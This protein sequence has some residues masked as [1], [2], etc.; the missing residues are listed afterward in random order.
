MG[1]TSPVYSLGL[2]NDDSYNGGGNFSG[3]PGDGFILR[4][5]ANTL[6]T[7]WLTY[8]GGQG[9]DALWGVD[10]YSDQRLAIVGYCTGA[11]LDYPLYDP[12]D[13]WFQAAPASA[14][15]V[16]ELL[17]P[18]SPIGVAETT[19]EQ[20]NIFPNPAHSTVRI[21]GDALCT[22]FRIVSVLDVS[23]RICFHRQYE[24]AA[25]EFSVGTLQDGCYVVRIL[26]RDGTLSDAK[27]VVAHE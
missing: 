19:Y 7:S 11:A 2:Y 26:H 24:G 25:V 18:E 4:L 10:T 6:S 22:G 13:A 21:I 27:L 8:F 1:S 16:A 3:Q 9:A 15:V 5:D 23:G 17:T 14:S 20:F 12:G